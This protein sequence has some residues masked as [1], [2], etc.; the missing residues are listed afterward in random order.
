MKSTFK[1]KLVI[2]GVLL[3]LFI[4]AFLYVTFKTKC[5]IGE[6][7]PEIRE[8]LIVPFFWFFLGLSGVLSIFLFLQEQIFKSWLKHIAWWYILLL[9]YFVLATPVYSSNIMHMDRGP[10][11][12]YGMILL[13]MISIPYSWYMRRKG[14]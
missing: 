3:C 5:F 2:K 4:C 6:C 11:A 8:G 1:K 14:D 10:L 7:N 13:G 12:S 9:T